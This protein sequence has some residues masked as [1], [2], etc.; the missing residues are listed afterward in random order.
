MVVEDANGG[1]EGSR[2]K[3]GENVGLV[4]GQ[5]MTGNGEFGFRVG[6]LDVVLGQQRFQGMRRQ[7]WRVEPQ[8]LGTSAW[9]SQCQGPWWEECMEVGR[10]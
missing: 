7:G 8:W 4:G 6:G 1:D 2:G 3:G 5:E 10:D 9:C